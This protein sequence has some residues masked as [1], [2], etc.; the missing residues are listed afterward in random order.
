MPPEKLE[1]E[2]TLKNF[3]CIYPTSQVQRDPC[4][5]DGGCLKESSDAPQHG[6]ATRD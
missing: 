5:T 6:R 3:N 1:C 2:I 4:I